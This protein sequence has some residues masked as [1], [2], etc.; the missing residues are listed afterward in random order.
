MSRALV[1]LHLC[2]LHPGC[3]HLGS[4]PHHLVPRLL[5]ISLLISSLQILPYPVS[6]FHCPLNDLSKIKLSSCLS[7]LK[8]FVGIY[9]LPYRCD[10]QD[11]WQSCPAPPSWPVFSWQLPCTNV[12]LYPDTCPKHIMFFIPSCLCTLH[13]CPLPSEKRRLNGLKS[14]WL[15]RPPLR[16]I[17]WFPLLCKHN[18][19]VTLV[20]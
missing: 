19:W 17:P 18:I 2:L 5:L 8:T 1:N 3:L 7:Y 15:F 20:V 4:D 11:S 13:H 6:P 9:Y 16:R 12:Q 14:I 10:L